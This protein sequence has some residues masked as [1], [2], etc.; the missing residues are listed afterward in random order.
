MTH[1]AVFR[2]GLSLRCCMYAG[3]IPHVR[4]GGVFENVLCESQWS[5]LQDGTGLCVP[6]FFS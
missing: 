6:Y 2:G 3:L 5:V 4:G 1:N